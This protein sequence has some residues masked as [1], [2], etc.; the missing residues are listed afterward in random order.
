MKEDEMK[1]IGE[2]IADVLKAPDNEELKRKV[3]SKV[4]EL[5]RSFPLYKGRLNYYEKELGLA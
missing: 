1:Y 4:E 5:C 2:L 3:R